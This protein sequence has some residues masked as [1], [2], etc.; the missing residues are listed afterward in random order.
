MTT[1]FDAENI[2]IDSIL[3]TVNELTL[4]QEKDLAEQAALKAEIEKTERAMRELRRVQMQKTETIRSRSTLILKAKTEAQR[5]ERFLEAKT[6]RD[7][8]KARFDIVSA[9]LDEVTKNAPW[10][11]F[12][13]KHQIDGGKRLAVAKRG[14]LADKR[15]L[16]KTLTSLVWLDMVKAKRVIVIAPN[17]IVSQFEGEI[18]EWAPDRVIFPLAGRTPAERAIIYP[19]LNMVKEFIITLNYE[20]WR[21]DKSIIDDLVSAGIDTIIC[22]EAHKIK[23]STKITARGVFQLAYR[24]N[25]CS[26]CN[27]VKNYLGS[28]EQ[29]NGV[30]KDYNVYRDAPLLM[31]CPSCSG[32]LSSTVENV[33]TMTGTPI[34]NKPQ[35]LFSMLY[36]VDCHRFDSEYNF[37]RDYCYSYAPNRWQ[38][39]HG[40]L[41]RLTKSMSEFFVQRTR[42]DA[43]IHIPPPS[44]KVYEIIKDK[45]KYKRQYEAERTLQNNAALVLENGDVNSILYMLE[46]MLR[47]R[48]IMTWPAGVE[49]KIKDENGEVINTLKFDVEESQ[50]L[51]EATD[52]LQELIDEEERVIVFSKF[53]APLYAMRN[54]FPNENMVMATGDQS[55]EMREMVVKDF[56][57][58]T[59]PEKPRWKVAFATYDAFA[60][61]LNL[62][63]ARHIIMLDD[64]WS[65]GM[66]DQAIGRIDRMNSVDQANVH[67]FRVKDSIDDFMA[68]LIEEKKKITSGFESSFDREGYINHLRGN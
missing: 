50:K 53:K 6:K 46:I 62:N 34:L 18:R 39:A 43:G 7:Q 20:A 40:G 29:A 65:P 44:I 63:A 33:L 37:L 19:M 47:E 49:L 9:E 41:E 28:W 2:D 14:I 45:V 36:L 8:L 57:L 35:E 54:R 25:F 21:R 59:A 32:K 10:R 60:T 23:S 42:D 56:D 67:I 68:G 15:G 55:K 17:D 3:A 66:Q 5:A 26:E 30:L 27:L 22:D 1:D 11:N 24:P 13:F 51:D 52:L 48:Q 31:V 38:F 12:A 16:G 4:Q 64:E 61:G 58:K